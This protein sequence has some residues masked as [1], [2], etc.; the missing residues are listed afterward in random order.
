MATAGTVYEPVNEWGLSKIPLLA[1]EG[2][3][4]GQLNAAKPPFFRADG[5]VGSD[6]FSI[7]AD[8]TTPSA[9]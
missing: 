5:V 2:W 6:K 8:L 4:R 9:P 3:M 7:F 1:E